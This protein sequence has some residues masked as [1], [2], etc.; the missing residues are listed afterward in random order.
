M[1]RSFTSRRTLQRPVLVAFAAAAA[2]VCLR[3]L[4]FV[5]CPHQGDTASA[6]GRRHALLAGT[7]TLLTGSD[8]KPAEA[9]YF[10]GERFDGSFV[11]SRFDCNQEGLG[12]P[13]GTC[14]RNINCGGGLATIWGKDSESGKMWKVLASYEG[15]NIQIDLRKKGGSLLEGKWFRNKKEDTKGIRWTDGS[16]WEKMEYKIGASPNEVMLNIGA[17]Y[18]EKV[19]AREAAEAATSK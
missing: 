1:T 16:T 18:N 4:S 8:S 2:V 19:A 3:C 7:A 13:A 15:E 5:P 14:L 17:E 6:A 12:L 11:D 10:N 9:Q